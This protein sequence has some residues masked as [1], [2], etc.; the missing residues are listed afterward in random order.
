MSGFSYGIYQERPVVV[1]RCCDR[2]VEHGPLGILTGR[3]RIPPVR[4]QNTRIS[5]KLAFYESPFEKRACKKG[6]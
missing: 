3:N 4:D 5:W 6:A 1:Y 2:L